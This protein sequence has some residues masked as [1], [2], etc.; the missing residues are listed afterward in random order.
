MTPWFRRL[1]VVALV[2][3]SAPAYGQ[4]RGSAAGSA[5][6]QEKIQQFRDSLR[7][8]PRPGGG[9]K[10]FVPPK[11]VTPVRTG[12]IGAAAYDAFIDPVRD[13]F[14]KNWEQYQKDLKKAIEDDGKRAREAKTAKERQK[15]E[16]YVKDYN[17]RLAKLETNDPPHTDIRAIMIAPKP[18]GKKG[19][20]AYEDF[21]EPARAPLVKNWQQYQDE[22][23][24]AIVEDGNR[25]RDAK[26]AAD[27]QKY[28]SYVTN[29]RQR[30]KWLEGNDPPHIDLRAL[31][32]TAAGAP[33]TAEVVPGDA[34]AGPRLADWGMCSD[35]ATGTDW[36]KSLRPIP[37]TVIDKGVLKFVPYLSFKAGDYE[38][39]VYGDPDKPAGIEIG[40]RGVA[41]DNAAAK[42][43][44]IEY[45]TR[46]LTADA[47]RKVVRSLKPAADLKKF[48]GLT[49]EVT[50]PTAEDAY[51][52]WWVS[53]Y[54]EAEL[55]KSRATPKE[56]A[57]ITVAK[58]DIKAVASSPGTGDTKPAAG[59]DEPR[60]WTTDDLKYAR[61]SG[62]SGGSV[63]VH[64]YTRKDGTYVRGH[65][66]AAPGTG[67]KRK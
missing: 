40:I 9:S 32:K 46:V 1:S 10:D 17:Q 62:G 21:I 55:D 37:A 4:I 3:A 67:N 8:G 61:P 19:A 41:L 65:T 26:S 2:F 47:D 33:P 6:A 34:P 44:C 30:L 28:E 36:G 39:N 14:L 35:A 42:A 57:A 48:G 13:A 5:E 24:K 22:L 20:A 15:Y 45:I 59:G 18:T 25:A 27:R 49:F 11:E 51:G 63:Y 54:D 38:I 29:Y 7:S 60:G 12:T 52:G 53:V 66:R 23:K 31:F 16:S 43:N 56:L 58:D 50:P 64:G